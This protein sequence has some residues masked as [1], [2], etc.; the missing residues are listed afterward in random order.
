MGKIKTT[1][2]DEL[3][4]ESS[5]RNSNRLRVYKAPN[6]EVT[7]HFRNFKIVLHTPEEIQEWKEG[8]KTALE[9][10]R[11]QDLENDI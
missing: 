4:P 9:N 3:I 7:I 6:D 5:D 11:P 8:F 2:V 10:L 1:F